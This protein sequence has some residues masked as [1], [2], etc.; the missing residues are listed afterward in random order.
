MAWCQW[1]YSARTQYLGFTVGA[2]TVLLA[3]LLP[4]SDIATPPGSDKLHHVLGFAFWASLC[5]WGSSLRYFVFASIIIALGGA[6][7]LIQPFV[8]RHGEWNDFWAD[9]AGV[10][11]A[12]LLHLVIRHVKKRGT[13]TA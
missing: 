12:S 11:L 8:H 5:A 10:A 13:N 7:E 1:L 6:I 2:A 9:T 3:T 4:V